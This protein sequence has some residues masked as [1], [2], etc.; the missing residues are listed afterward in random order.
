[1]L[2]WVLSVVPFCHGN[3]CG[4]LHVGRFLCMTVAVQVCFR[5]CQ[6]LS[7]TRAHQPCPEYAEE[8][9]VKVAVGMAA[10]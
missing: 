3:R 4:A 1:M 5:A 2:F 10:I 7:W 6:V 9:S 8:V